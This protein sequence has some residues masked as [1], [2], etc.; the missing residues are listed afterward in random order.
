MKSATHFGH[1]CMGLAF[2]A[3]PL[4]LLAGCH[5]AYIEATVHNSTGGPVS[6]L[7]VDYPSA[8]F[9]TESLPHGADF[10]YRFKV[11]GSGSTKVLWTDAK[12]QDHTVAG[13][14]LQEGAEGHLLVTLSSS[15]ASWDVNIHPAR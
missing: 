12:H 2:V 4:L 6:V 9:G 11:L 10:H 14:P 3:S 7:E 8:S 5:S 13:P 15:N 1:R